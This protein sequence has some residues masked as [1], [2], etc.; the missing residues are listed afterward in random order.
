MRQGKLGTALRW[1]TRLLLILAI[2]FIM[3]VALPPLWFAVFP[4]R[5]PVMPPGGTRVQMPNGISLNVI[6]KGDGPPVILVH[7]CPGCAYDWTP[8][9]DA[10][11]SH[12]YRV[13]AYDRAGY[14]HSEPRSEGHD[15]T[16]EYAVEELLDLLSALDVSKAVVVGWSYG[17]GIAMLAAKRNPSRI[18]RLV[19]VGSVGPGSE[20]VPLH[21]LFN[22]LNAGPVVA[23]LR[24][25]PPASRALQRS[26]S[27]E[28]F[29]GEHPTPAW[30][31]AAFEA[32]L[33][34]SAAKR[35]YRNEVLAFR[36]VGPDPTGITG[37]V[38]VIHGEADRIVP[39]SIAAEIHRRTP[40]A[41]LLI[42]PGGSHMLPITHAD[43]IAD[44]IVESSTK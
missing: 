19:L 39:V 43:L 22:A 18:S 41:E 12:G 40:R 27:R 31:L 2:L 11:A 16:I 37:P 34:G 23:W 17:G 6:I 1:T 4:E 38:L 21:P 7:G 24:A 44:K 10:L 20:D 29:G 30:W 32:N 9:G 5:A 36:G 33:A 3:A 35:T 28:M 25:V 8:V 42:V 14:G 26:V 15:Y 13:I